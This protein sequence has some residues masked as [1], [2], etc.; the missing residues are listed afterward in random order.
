VLITVKT[1]LLKQLFKSFNKV[2]SS[3]GI[4]CWKVGKYFIEISW[5]RDMRLLKKCRISCVNKN[6]IAVLFTQSWGFLSSYEDVFSVSRES[7]SNLIEESCWGKSLDFCVKHNKVILVR[8]LLKYSY[9]DFSYNKV[10]MLQ[11][12]YIGFGFISKLKN[13][14]K[15]SFPFSDKKFSPF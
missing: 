8:K 15:I 13:P 14:S 7:F 11:K 1:S 12:I 4:R 9:Y 2:F 5:S 6:S 10:N 3:M